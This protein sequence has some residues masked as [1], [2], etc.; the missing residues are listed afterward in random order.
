M[1]WSASS[2]DRFTLGEKAL[3]TQRSTGRC[4]SQSPSGHFAEEILTTFVWHSVR[5]SHYADWA[6]LAHL[7][8]RFKVSIAGCGDCRSWHVILWCRTVWS[9]MNNDCGVRCSALWKPM[10]GSCSSVLASAHFSRRTKRPKWMYT[11]CRSK[12]SLRSATRVPFDNNRSIGTQNTPHNRTRMSHVQS[13]DIV[14]NL[15]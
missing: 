12:P 5:T 13:A 6:I 15:F 11:N 10:G 8:N 2:S 4:G 7:G 9:A 1:G 3:I 14:T